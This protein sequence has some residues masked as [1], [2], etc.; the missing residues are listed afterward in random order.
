M[1]VLSVYPVKPSCS[2]WIIDS[3]AQYSEYSINE[4][5][6]VWQTYM[7]KDWRRGRQGHL[8]LYFSA[9][10]PTCYWCSVS[11]RLLSLRVFWLPRMTNSLFVQYWRFVQGCSRGAGSLWILNN[12]CCSLRALCW[13]WLWSLTHFWPASESLL[14]KWNL[15]DFSLRRMLLAHEPN[16]SCS[17]LNMN[18]SL[19]K[20]STTSLMS[21]LA[22]CSLQTV[23]KLN[24]GKLKSNPTTL[25]LLIKTWG[26][27]EKFDG[28]PPP[29]LFQPLWAMHHFLSPRV[30]R[31]YHH[32]E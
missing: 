8:D 9:E 4:W 21:Y 14:K 11:P 12:K 3:V 27:V 17:W 30:W 1:R 31:Y 26:D 7:A 23:A 28:T 2:R 25:M 5:G 24:D 19:V 18:K 10:K 20:L 16:I 22:S 15:T 29:S 6:A 13:V 32:S